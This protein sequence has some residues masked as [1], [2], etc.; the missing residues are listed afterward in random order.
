MCA[1]APGIETGLEAV[2]P[3]P[4]NPGFTLVYSSPG[5]TNVT[6]EYGTFVDNFL[7]AG[8]SGPNAV[9]M[10]MAPACGTDER[11][12]CEPCR[13]SKIRAACNLCLRGAGVCELHQWRGGGGAGSVLGRQPR[14]ALHQPGHR[15]PSV[16]HGAELRHHNTIAASAAVAAAAAATTAVVAAA[17]SVV[18]AAAACPRHSQAPPIRPL[19][20]VVWQPV[21]AAERQWSVPLRHLCPGEESG[22]WWVGRVQQ[23]GLE[24]W[25][26]AAAVSHTHI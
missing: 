14:G 25:P 13:R 4:G 5:I 19:V 24:E 6:A 9:R 17:A 8:G 22:E 12:G 11:D 10:L 2:F 1:S 3:A 21:G 16:L 7:G 26:R 20:D 18:A 15:D 23:S